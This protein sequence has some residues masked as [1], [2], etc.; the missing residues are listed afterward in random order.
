MTMFNPQDPL[1]LLES[2]LR[3]GP[4]ADGAVERDLIIAIAW[5]KRGNA[6]LIEALETLMDEQNGPP[7]IRHAAAWQAAMDLATK[8][9]TTA[10][11][12]TP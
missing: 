9:L 8:A 6:E 10:K 3:L 11:G 4:S 5:L 1:L 7:L 2:L 12:K